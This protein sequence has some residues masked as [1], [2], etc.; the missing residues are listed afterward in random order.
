MKFRSVFFLL[1]ALLAALLAGCG[2]S[3][4]A[5]KARS[6]G[7]INRGYIVPAQQVRVAEYLNYYDQRFPE[8]TSGA[9]LAMDV[10]LG[11]TLTS[12]QDGEA[13]VQ[14]GLQAV[15]ASQERPTPLNL[16]LVLDK[17]GSMK[18][19]DKMDYLKQSLDVF[20]NSLQPDDIIAIVAYSD[21]VQVLLPAQRVGNGGWVRE[22]IQRLQ[23]GGWTN[24]HAGLMQGF[25]EVE[26]NFDIRRN[27]RVLLLTDGIANRGV[28]D[29]QRIAS[30][31][32]AYN[33]RGIYLSTIGLGVDLDDALL[34]M[35]A[36]QGHGA[37]HFIDSGQEMERVFREEAGS[38]VEKVARDITITIEADAGKLD[39]L[40][41]YQ[42]SP[43]PRGA[44]VQLMDMGAG[45][46]QALLAKFKMG[47]VR[48]QVTVARITLTY[49]DVFGQRQRSE[50]RV[51]SIAPGSAYEDP[52]VDI[53]VRRNVSIVRSAQALQ[54]IDKLFSAG[55]Y[56]EARDL[57]RQMEDE[58]RE[59]AQLTGDRQMVEDADL[60]RRY[61]MTLSEALDEMQPD[62]PAPG[63]TP[64]APSQ[65]QRWGPAVTPVPSLPS[66]TLE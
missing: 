66:V 29:P 38:L 10:R 35:L 27:N 45:D 47:R 36:Q 11:N 48:N 33:D 55:R 43:S 23:P 49:T 22:T 5:S 44:R 6:R 2:S 37:Y 62:E 25:A 20:L 1:L 19:A 50:T 52:L 51:A 24:L 60:F 14:V 46:S 58:L 17:S 34:H 64:V 15:P 8:P 12:P 18:E 26:K 21:E 4:E 61:Q 13:W 63:S 32:K 31:A 30:E 59:M 42:G 57:A 39:Y 53:E 16:A 56:G 9:P 65:P 41:G 28:I 3:M 7:L 40:V 54:R